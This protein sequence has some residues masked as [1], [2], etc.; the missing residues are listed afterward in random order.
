MSAPLILCHKQDRIATIRLNR[1][2][3]MNTFTPEFADQLDAALW[4]CER[5]PEVLVVLIEAAGPHFC[6]GIALDQFDDKSAQQYRDFLYRI[7]AFYHTLA[8]M[9]TLTIAVVQ[10]YALAN[11][12]GLAFAADFTVAADS[13]QFGTTA[14]NVGLICLGPAAPMLRILGRKKTLEMVLTGEII[15]AQKALE[16]G[17]INR[18]VA[19]DQLQ[20]S[21]RQLAESLCRKS[22]LALRIG[23][24]GINRLGDNPC[25]DEALNSMDDLFA[26]LCATADAQEGVQAF[27]QKRQP[28]WQ[29]R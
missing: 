28:V 26:S 24:E 19:E 11:G 27:R 14:I 12:A 3:A 7:D 4:Q 2:D 23:K 1:P 9:K 15:S 18:V 5:D 10:G 20:H 29:E 25:Y 22:P 17:L 21:A 8:R 13:A 16:L 6:T